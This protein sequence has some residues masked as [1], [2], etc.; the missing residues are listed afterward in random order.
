MRTTHLL[1]ASAVCAL[2]PGCDGGALT[3]PVAGPLAYTDFQC[4]DSNCG[5]TTVTPHYDGNSTTTYSWGWTQTGP[6]S[7][8]PAFTHVGKSWSTINS[9]R[10]TYGT[11]SSTATVYL[12]CNS[13]EARVHGSASKTVYGVGKALVSFRY[14][15]TSHDGF[16]VK[17]SHFFKASSSYPW[18]TDVSFTSQASECNDR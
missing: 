18:L 15:T 11:V 12:N 8:G 10:Y 7:S 16:G 17:A 2:L 9:D 4:P 13:G 3:A 6:N 1:L 5:G 14:V